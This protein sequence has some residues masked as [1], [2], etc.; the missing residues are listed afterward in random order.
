MW[1]SARRASLRVVKAAHEGGLWCRPGHSRLR[2]SAKLALGR[3][4]T[5]L[6]HPHPGPHLLM[7]L[8]VTEAWT[9]P[10]H[11]YYGRRLLEPLS[12]GAPDVGL[13][14]SQLLGE[15]S[16]RLSINEPPGTHTDLNV[17][18]AQSCPQ[19]MQSLLK[20]PVLQWKLHVGPTSRVGHNCR[21]SGDTGKL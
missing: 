8:V 2:G 12:K 9:W 3:L 18:G 17:L 14:I 6:G 11:V 19:L 15:V 13:S 1:G 7:D 16:P 20:E 21:S 5:V 10:F 4:G